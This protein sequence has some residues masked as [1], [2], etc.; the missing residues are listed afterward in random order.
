MGW[1]DSRA[2]L[3]RAKHCV[4]GI[5]KARRDSGTLRYKQM[6]SI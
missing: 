3:V 1:K 2:L 5:P 6:I 4:L